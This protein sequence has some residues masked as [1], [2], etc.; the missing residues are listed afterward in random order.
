MNDNSKDFT[1]KITSKNDFVV[2][3]FKGQMNKHAKDQLETCLQE[4][5]SFDSKIIILLFK[6]IPTIDG[7][8]LRQLTLIQ[9]EI[10]KKNKRLALTGLSTILKNFLYDKGIIRLNEIHPSLEELLNAKKN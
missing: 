10:R 2:V 7:A 3:S 4:L 9:Q 6:D 1:Y 8:V 5:I